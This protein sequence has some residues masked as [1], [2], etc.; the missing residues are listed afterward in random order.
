M[1]GVPTFATPPGFLGV[2][3]ADRDAALVVAGIPFDIDTTNRAG[4]RDGPAAMRRA[5]RMLVDGAH[6]GS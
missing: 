4:T 5:S 2:T 1:A 6:P 3:R